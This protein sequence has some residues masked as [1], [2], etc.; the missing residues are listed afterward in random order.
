[1]NVL[2]LF[3]KHY[4]EMTRRERREYKRWLDKHNIWDGA[5]VSENM[6]KGKWY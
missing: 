5:I 4:N 6:E 3:E 2:S 1:M